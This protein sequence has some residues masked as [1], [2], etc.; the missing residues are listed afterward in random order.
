VRLFFA[1]LPGESQI[2][3]CRLI[4]EA[5][6]EPEDGLNWVAS[7]N[8]HITMLFIGECASEELEK[9]T[10]AVESLA[11]N[12]APIRWR[13]HRTGFFP[14]RG[15]ARVLFCGI[16]YEGFAMPL[17]AKG[18]R[19]S[20]QQFSQKELKDSFH[21]HITLARCRNGLAPRQLDRFKKMAVE[22]LDVVSHELICFESRRENNILR[23]IPIKRFILTGQ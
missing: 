3:A 16:R 14:K 15:E 5:I 8:M 21:P 19:E 2:D 22:P 18:L 20:W 1:L 12:F 11:Q 7:E 4:Q 10:P 17:L 6:R 23:Y 9:Y 13:L